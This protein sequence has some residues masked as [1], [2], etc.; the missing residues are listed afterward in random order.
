MLRDGSR[1]GCLDADRE[2]REVVV[3]EHDAALGRELDD[4]TTDLAVVVDDLRQ[5]EAVALQLVAVL[6]SRSGHL[7]PALEPRFDRGELGI[8]V[9]EEEEIAE[10]TEERRDTERELFGGG[11]GRQ[12]HRGTFTNPGDEHVAVAVDQLVEHGLTIRRNSLLHQRNEMKGC[13]GDRPRQR[14]T[15]PE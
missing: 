11:D 6:G 4:A 9:A 10:L 14:A 2:H 3:G 1:H 5:G 13:P 12:A 7:A 8:G 15:A